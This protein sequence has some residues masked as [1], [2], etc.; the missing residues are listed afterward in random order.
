MQT[1]EI[2]LGSAYDA[3]GKE[4]TLLHARWK[5]FRQLFSTK[6]AVA[7]INASAGLAGWVIQGALIDAVILHLTRLCESARTGKQKNL[8]LEHLIGSLPVDPNEDVTDKLRNKL[9]KIKQLSLPFQAKRN[10]RI[11]HTDLE[12][13]LDADKALPGIS[14]PQI[15]ELLK[16][17]RSFMAL[18]HTHYG[19]GET[20]YEGVITEGDDGNALLRTLELARRL[21]EFE[22]QVW[23]SEITPEELFEKVKNAVRDS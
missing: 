8:T 20:R 7:L 15:E 2:D 17:I 13:A 19:M 5:L 12:H 6:E 21:V 4:V 18:I 14:V 11:A 23:F 3:I 22:K 1:T 16:A 10:K 9:A